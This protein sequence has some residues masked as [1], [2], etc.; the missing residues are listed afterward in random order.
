M[1]FRSLSSGIRVALFACSRD[2]LEISGSFGAVRHF[3]K[4]DPSEQ[5]SVA[6]SL[7]LHL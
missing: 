2:S 6:R 3:G 5:S 4:F 7:H 1:D